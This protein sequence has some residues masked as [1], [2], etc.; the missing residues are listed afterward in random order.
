MGNYLGKITT[1]SD[2]KFVTSGE[3]SAKIEVGNSKI[4]SGSPYLYQTLDHR[5]GNYTS[6]SV[7][8]LLSVDIYNACPESKNVYISLDFSVGES[9]KTRYEI[10]PQKWTTLYYTNYREYMPS[11]ICNGI[12]VRF[13]AVESGVNTFYVDNLRI[14]RTD[15]EY[16]KVNPKLA[17]NEICSFDRYEQ[18]GLLTTITDGGSVDTEMTTENT[19]TGSGCA[20]KIYAGH[21]VAVY[22]Q[23]YNYPGIGLA[24]T[25]LALV[26]FGSYG[27][28]DYL[29]FDIYSDNGKKIT[30]LFLILTNKLGVRYF[31]YM[32]GD[33]VVP[34]RWTTIRIPVSKIN[35]GVPAEEGFSATSKIE[36]VWGEFVGEDRVFYLDNFRME[37]GEN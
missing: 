28:N 17:E 37:T 16:K 31:D 36:L 18:I 7:V 23:S 30:D 34:E 15:S 33:Q 27:A 10:G 9:A 20:L 19:S 1:N 8:K 22:P 32:F 12:Y 6:F 3:K 25:I 21:G 2:A 24:E 5:F 14:Y 29:C 11:E 35:E 26:P 13:D 4:F